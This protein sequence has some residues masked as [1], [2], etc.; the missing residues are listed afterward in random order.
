MGSLPERANEKLRHYFEY[1][2]RR[3]QGQEVSEIAEALG[4]VHDFIL[5]AVLR[6][7]GFPVCDLCGETPAPANHCWE[8]SGGAER[9]QMRLDFTGFVER[10]IK[11]LAELGLSGAS[12]AT[13]K[14]HAKAG[15][16]VRLA[17]G[18][19]VHVKLSPWN[20][21][22][23]EAP[24][25]DT[26]PLST[27]RAILAAVVVVQAADVDPR[28]IRIMSHLRDA[29]FRGGKK[30]W[31]TLQQELRTDPVLKDAAVDDFAE[32]ISEPSL[33]DFLEGLARHYPRTPSFQELS[34]NERAATLQRLYER[35]KGVADAA[36]NL[37]KFLEQGMPERLPTSKVRDVERYIFAAELSGALRLNSVEIG[38]FMR[39]PVDSEYYEK[40]HQNKTAG[41]MIRKGK[42]LL[43]QIFGD[44]EGYETH[45]ERI[46]PALEVLYNKCSVEPSGSWIE[47][48]AR[49][50]WDNGLIRVLVGRQA[51]A[52]WR[53]EPVNSEDF[54]LRVM[55]TTPES[56]STSGTHL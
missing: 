9:S 56:D 17:D 12:K 53:K 55:L 41:D 44:S 4:Y 7:S 16:P 22:R 54:S 18:R 46:R 10:K 20:S 39:V 43:L 36:G 8:D 25:A 29:W 13:R 30:S 1:C 47:E 42:E 2:E 15:S 21:D 23:Y 35:V 50:Q 38:E 14:T 40:K 34:P 31:E 26:E 3:M 33:L 45:F 37:Q 19:T 49:A 11:E 5:L 32:L 52:G 48:L 51:L 28:R 6:E 27:D 24:L